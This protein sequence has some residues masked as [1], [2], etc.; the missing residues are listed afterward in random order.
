MKILVGKEKEYKISADI[1]FPPETVLQVVDATGKILESEHIDQM[2]LADI[3]L[4][5]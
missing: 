5:M 4:N 1:V 3:T 2:D